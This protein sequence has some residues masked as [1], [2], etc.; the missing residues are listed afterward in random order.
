MATTDPIRPLLA[1]VDTDHA[2]AILGAMR[3]VAEAGRGA[4]PADAEA[5]R[6]AARYM[7]GYLGPVD[8]A[9]APLI[10]PEALAAKVGA[11]GPRE[12]SVRFLAIMALIDPPLDTGKLDAALRYAEA[13]G[14]HARFVDEIT[15]AAQKRV[16]EALAD[17][18]RANMESILGRPW[19]GGPVE[20]WMLPY[21]GTAADPALVARF[22]ALG[23]LA[24][25]TFG[26]AFWR[27]FK[28]NGYAFPG[29]P[30]GLNAAFSVPHDSV[31]TLTG[32]GT[33]G[34]GEILAST[35]TAMMHHALPMAGHVLPVIFSWHLA[36]EINRV[37][38]ASAGGL[39][40]KEI[41][42]ALAAG[43]QCPAD[44]FAPGWPFWS[45]VG[46]PIDEVRR[47]WRIPPSGLDCG[48]S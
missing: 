31:H 26:H 34:R 4:K 16:S 12:D 42:R 41:W 10:A 35:F 40:P 39:D 6:S 47:D 19:A 24:E 1:D 48:D 27:H 36:T 22:E 18:A 25:T 46:R 13:L 37:A 14:V 33:T 8:P 17:M 3:S 29:D 32:Y 20:G 5:L 11:A 9:A 44:S 30:A 7:L 15:E 23:G 28:R 2:L 43:A 45:Q 21:A 38:G